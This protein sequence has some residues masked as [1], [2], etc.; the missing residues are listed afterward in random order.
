MIS[1]QADAS[2]PP[3]Q[4]APLHL[5]LTLR[6][7]NLLST[8][9]VEHHRHRPE[10]CGFAQERHPYPHERIL[11]KLSV[12]FDGCLPGNTPVARGPNPE[13]IRY[14]GGS[15]QASAGNCPSVSE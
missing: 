7:S 2:L 12:P 15:E 14:Q 13:T 6:T 4:I 8:S 9:G 3:V 10:L 1:L 11:E 5:H